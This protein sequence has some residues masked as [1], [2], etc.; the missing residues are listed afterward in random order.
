MA[1]ISPQ[2]IHED[3]NTPE[4]MQRPAREPVGVLESFTQHTQQ[5]TIKIIE[6]RVLRWYASDGYCMVSTLFGKLLRTGFSLGSSQMHYLLEE[7]Y[8]R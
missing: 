2:S 4:P 7:C 5:L 8:D 1:F 3:L 6:K